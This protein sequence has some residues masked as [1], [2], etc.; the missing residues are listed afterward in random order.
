M[1]WIFG[2]LAVGAIALIA[3]AAPA[4]AHH[5]FGAEFDRDAPIRLEGRDGS[6][7]VGQPALLDSPR[8][9]EGRRHPGSLDGRGRNSEHPSPTGPSPGLPRSRHGVRSWTA[10]W[11]RTTR[12]AGRTAATSPSAM[13]ASSSWARQGP[14]HRTMARSPL[15]SR[16]RAEPRVRGN[17]EQ[18]TGNSGEVLSSVPTERAGLQQEPALFVVACPAWGDGL[19]VKST[20]GRAGLHQDPGAPVRVRVSGSRLFPVPSSLFPVLNQLNPIHRPAAA[21]VNQSAMEANPTTRVR[22][23][24]SSAPRRSRRSR[25]RKVNRIAIGSPMIFT[26]HEVL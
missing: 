21:T 20:P 16:G 23:E 22:C 19:E 14:V 3:Y 8:R 4:V 5:A 1:R 13:A 11:P 24:V 7:G 15:R 12:C 17:R 26:H 18:G 25:T 2:M 9:A 6:S 10:T